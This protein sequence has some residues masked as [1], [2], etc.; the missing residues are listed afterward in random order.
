[1]NEN[2]TQQGLGQKAA[3]NDGSRAL[4]TTARA[5]LSPLSRAHP[6]TDFPGLSVHVP[7]LKE[8]FLETP[9]LPTPQPD[10]RPLPPQGSHTLLCS[11]AEHAVSSLL[12]EAT[13]APLLGWAMPSG[14]GTGLGCRRSLC[15][16][17]WVD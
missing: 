14:P 11:A 15:W 9:P 8:A 7:S 10:G 6:A 4:S 5:H 3:G 12:A 16:P 2:A 1:M 13:P 17:P